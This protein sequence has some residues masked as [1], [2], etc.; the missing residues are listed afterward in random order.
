MSDVLNFHKQFTSEELDAQYNLRAGRP[1]YEVTVIPSWQARSEEAR[2]TLDKKLDIRY[3]D[4]EKQLLG[5]G[6]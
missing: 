2:D 5:A 6:A 1:D 4:G 3:G